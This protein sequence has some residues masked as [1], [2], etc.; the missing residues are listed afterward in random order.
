[1]PDQHQTV[2][3]PVQAILDRIDAAPRLRQVDT[4]DLVRALDTAILHDEMSERRAY[5]I[6]MALPH[7]GLGI[8]TDPFDSAREMYRFLRLRR[9]PHRALGV[10][11][12]DFHMDAARDLIE[13]VG[14][15]LDPVHG[16][17][18]FFAR[19][20]PVKDGK[21]MRTIPALKRALRANR[22]D[23]HDVVSFDVLDPADVFKDASRFIAV[24]HPTE[25]FRIRPRLKRRFE[26]YF[27]P[28]YIVFAN[29]APFPDAAMRLLQADSTFKHGDARQRYAL[30]ENLLACVPVRLI[31][32]A[33]G[34]THVHVLDDAFVVQAALQELDITERLIDACYRLEE[35]I[36]DPIMTGNF[37]DDYETTVAG[38][39]RHH[40]DQ[41]TKG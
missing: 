12:E 38:R 16:H 7:N 22:L 11:L 35:S 4:N 41:R 20:L 17:G 36:E 6:L 37:V 26:Y 33:D 27:A 1:M 13:E 2:P 25:P 23:T 31:S 14:D 34:F 15:I 24:C 19:H 28:H 8:P 29:R 30:L 5:D 39:L 3:A 9:T 32:H 40:R 10:H 18:E 21:T